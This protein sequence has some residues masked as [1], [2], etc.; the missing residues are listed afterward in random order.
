MADLA[1]VFHWPPSV[2]EGMSLS[3]LMGWRAMAEKRSRPPES[4]GKRGKR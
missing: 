2:M 4:T 3:E 1:V